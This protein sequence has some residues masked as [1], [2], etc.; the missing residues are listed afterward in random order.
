MPILHGRRHFVTVK[1]VTLAQP[2]AVPD[3][4]GAQN[5]VQQPWNYLQ[6][7]NEAMRR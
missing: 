1:P 4:S 6:K 3:L 5:V 7:H 2:L